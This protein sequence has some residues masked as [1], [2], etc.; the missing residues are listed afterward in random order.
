M[1][2]ESNGYVRRCWGK[3]RHHLDGKSRRPD[4]PRLELL[5]ANSFGALIS[6]ETFESPPVGKKCRRAP[7]NPEV[8]YLV[9]NVIPTIDIE[10]F[11]CDKF[12]AIVREEGGRE[13]DV[14]DADEAASR[15]L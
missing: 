10:C 8:V 11:A 3:R 5:T 4:L 1:W 13:A 9:Y 6:L 12:C 2:G 7:R 15:S 14:V